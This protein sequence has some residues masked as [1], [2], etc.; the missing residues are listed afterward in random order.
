MN[1]VRRNEL[2]KVIDGLNAI[3]DKDS[4]YALI[5]EL[6]NIKYDEEDYYGNIPEN[7]QGSQR[8]ESSEQAIESL[9]EALELLNE[10]CDEEDFNNDDERIQD[11][12]NKIE[13]AI[14]A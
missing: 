10:I 14:W 5:D 13:D 6:D 7:L 2:N 3:Q 11:V 9:D 1:N 4:L 12:I 8:A